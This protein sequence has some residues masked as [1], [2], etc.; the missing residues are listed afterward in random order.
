ML[1]HHF[2]IYN[3]YCILGL[4]SSSSVVQWCQ[5]LPCW[6]W[7]SIASL[8]SG[9]TWFDYLFNGARYYGFSCV[10]FYHFAAS[11]AFSLICCIFIASYCFS[12]GQ[13]CTSINC[14][15]ILDYW[16]LLAS[17]LA[18]G[19]IVVTSATLILGTIVVWACCCCF[20]VKQIRC[21]GTSLIV[22]PAALSFCFSRVFL[23]IRDHMLNISRL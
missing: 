3:L 6:W 1:H 8:A 2:T 17:T 22:W 19:F 11:I 16:L 21:L 12:P 14:F 7:P 4:L 23:S 9:L 20:C 10:C 15:L 13:V 18:A 5:S